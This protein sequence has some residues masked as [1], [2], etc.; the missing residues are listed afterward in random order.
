MEVLVG[1]SEGVD[2]LHCKEGVLPVHGVVF[3]G[4]FVLEPDDPV[5]GGRGFGGAADGGHD[6]GG[7]GGELGGEFGSS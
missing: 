4:G 3:F 7:R 6:L 2:S 5:V 1:F